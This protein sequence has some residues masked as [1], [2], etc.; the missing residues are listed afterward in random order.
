M[1]NK[2]TIIVSDVNGSKHYTVNQIIKKILF[3]FILF[4]LLFVLVGI[5][6]IKILLNE[7][8]NINSKK[9]LYE[10]QAKILLQ[11][12]I[13]LS[14]KYKIVKD[15]IKQKSEIQINKL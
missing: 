6:W 9:L 8:N 4:I 1:R 7:L 15:K 10:K 11:K 13:N 12:N 2:L 5:I 3:Y 14:N